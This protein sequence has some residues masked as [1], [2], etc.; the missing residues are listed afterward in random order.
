MFETFSYI[1]VVEAFLGGLV[2]GLSAIIMLTGLGRIAGVSGLAARVTGI[3]KSSIS[4]PSALAFIISLPMGA[5][6]VSNFSTAIPIEFSDN[7]WLLVLGGLF[8]GFGTRLGSGCTSRHGH[9]LCSAS[10]ATL[11]NCNRN[12]HAGGLCGGRCAANY[13]NN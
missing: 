9:M 1:I 12:I 11:Y 7:I 13:G 3:S 2:I 6:I 5:T 4:R 10:F 8:V